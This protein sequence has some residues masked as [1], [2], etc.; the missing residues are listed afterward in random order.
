LD[1]H[2]HRYRHRCRRLFSKMGF[3]LHSALGHHLNYIL[4]IEY[5]LYALRIIALC[6]SP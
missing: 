1:H 2:R 6:H 3:S 4:L 5:M